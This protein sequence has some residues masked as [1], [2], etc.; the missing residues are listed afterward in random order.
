VTEA[1]EGVILLSDP[2]VAAIPVEECGEPLVDV[3]AVEGP[4]ARLLVA[5]RYADEAGAWAH[6]REG[7]LHRLL[8]A[9]RTL[10]DGIGLLLV[11]GYRPPDLQA[12]YFATYRGWLAERHP[13]RSDEVVHAAA[14]RYVSPPAVAPHVAGAAVDVTL[15]RLDGGGELDLGTEVNATPEDSEGRC[16]TG[17]PALDRGAAA[18]RGLLSAALATAGFVNYPTEWWHWSFGDRY[19]ALMTGTPSAPYGPASPGPL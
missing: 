17:H 19:W 18:N 16:F 6:V 15:C 5:R 9:A 2:R 13:E 8:S 1:P 11:E 3:R 12:R 4:A 14:S 7:V 10:P